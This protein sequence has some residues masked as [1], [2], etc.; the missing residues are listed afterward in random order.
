MNIGID[1]GSSYSMWSSY[2]LV[3]YGGATCTV[4]FIV[5]EIPS[6]AK[7]RCCRAWYA[8]FRA[9]RRYVRACEAYRNAKVSLYQAEETLRRVQ[10]FRDYTF[11]ALDVSTC[12]WFLREKQ[13]ELSA[14]DRYC[15]E[16]SVAVIRANMLM[17]DAADLS[18]GLCE[19]PRLLHSEW[20]D[21]NESHTL[22]GW[23]V[24]WLLNDI[25][26]RSK[27]TNSVQDNRTQRHDFETEAE[28]ERPEVNHCADTGC[29]M[30]CRS[31][32]LTIRKMG[33][34]I[35]HGPSVIPPFGRDGS[36]PAAMM[37][38]SRRPLEKAA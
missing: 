3:D 30:Q 25:L 20:F 21:C 23:G 33:P 28:T 19:Y 17:D 38:A 32:K 2:I 7:R 1:F 10:T 36:D 37:D 15:S 34:G 12:E 35:S 22:T 31:R 24:D 8:F 14:A 26:C 6:T 27:E 5:E 11:A 13:E 4:S 16:A 18:Y 29:R 9:V